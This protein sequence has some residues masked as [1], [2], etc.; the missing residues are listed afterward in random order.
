MLGIDEVMIVVV[1]AVLTLAFLS[2]F[3]AHPDRAGDAGGVPEPA[4]PPITWASRSKRI[5]SLVWGLSGM[6]AAVAGILVCLQRRD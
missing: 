3:L 5:H 2:V 1:T 6:V 4:W